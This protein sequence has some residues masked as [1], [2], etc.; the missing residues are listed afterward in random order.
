MN[1]NSFKYNV[2]R[3][4]EREGYRVHPIWNDNQRCQ[5]D[6]LS[7]NPEGTVAGVKCKAHGHLTKDE[8]K[9]LMWY[10]M[11]IFIASEKYGVGSSEI[12]KVKIEKLE[13][14]K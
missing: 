9:E 10:D 1:G 11:P 13:E 3:K 6:L 5:F 4:L 12:H 7:V 14:E 2:I 8:K